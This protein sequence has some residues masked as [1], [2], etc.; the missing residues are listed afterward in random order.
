MAAHVIQQVRDA[1]IAALSSPPMPNCPNVFVWR[2]RAQ[3]ATRTPFV[4]VQTGDDQV[5]EA[6]LGYP[7]LEDI[8]VN[9]E[10]SIVVF[11]QGDYEATALNIRNDVERVFYPLTQP[12]TL[13]GKLVRLTRT[14][15]HIAQDDSG[16]KPT[17]AIH[18]Q[19]QAD[20][21]HLVSQ[22]DSFIY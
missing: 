22:P 1:L 15:A 14:G 19:V 9:F 10:V 4:Y 2:D 11:Q 6:S 7:N 5:S 3:D 21:R 20:I 18:L 17:Y 8:T 16:G 12:Q 13:A